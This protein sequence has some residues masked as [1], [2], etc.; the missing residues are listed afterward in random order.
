MKLYLKKNGIRILA[1]VVVAAVA[2][3]IGVNMSGGTGLFKNAAGA[4]RLPLQ[5]AVTS[6]ANYL[7]GVY[8]YLYEYDSLKAERDD[9]ELR[10][11]EAEEKVRQA[12]E[13]LE[14]NERLRDLLD[15]RDRHTDFVFESARIVSWNASN[16]ASDFT[17][18]KGSDNGV[19]MGNPVVTETGALVGQVIEL[20]DT[21]ATVRT[22]IDVDMNV[23]ALVGEAGNAAM[24][25]GDF[26]LM[27]EGKVKLT[28][29]TEGT[30]L[31]IGDPIYTSG[32]GG[33]FPQGLLI[34]HIYT[35]NTEGGQTQ[36]AVID[37]DCDLGSVAQVFVIKEFDI[38]E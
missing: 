8:G 21:W 38:V 15:L 27:H 9:L 16:W 13:A 31:L 12:N 14:E 24:I 28:H 33:I 6:I 20:G 26:T 37:P 7:E 25:V 3:L 5:S 36:Y 4:L 32:K 17:I 2:V 18:S 11:A 35:V 1:L 19:E 34:G 10:L 29:L 22:V 23:G 30:Q